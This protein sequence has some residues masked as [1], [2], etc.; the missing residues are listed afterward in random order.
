MVQTIPSILLKLCPPELTHILAKLYNKCL[1]ES[2][3]PSCWKFSTV[4]P[5]YENDGERSDPG[6]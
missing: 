5:A 6:N 3:F 2:C 4:V 1:F